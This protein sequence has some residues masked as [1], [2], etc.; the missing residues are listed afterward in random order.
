MGM[1]QAGDVLL[2]INDQSLHNATLRDAADLLQCVGDVVTLK[3]SKESSAH[4]GGRGRTEMVIYTVE[5]HRHGQSLGITL[6]GMAQTYMYIHT[7]LHDRH[8]S[9]R[10]YNTVLAPYHHC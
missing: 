5:L 10:F 8:S 6:T 7:W 4:H 1:L 2:A 3:V 9:L